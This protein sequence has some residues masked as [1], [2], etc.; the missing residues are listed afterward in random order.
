[1]NR[2]QK[3]VFDL[4]V[5]DRELGF[6]AE[7]ILE[8][9]AFVPSELASLALHEVFDLQLFSLFFQAIQVLLIKKIPNS[10]LPPISTQPG[11][12]WLRT[13]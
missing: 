1:M 11:C 13:S 4:L 5:L 7:N 10:A 2:L 9:P 12:S 8:L 6:L 3:F